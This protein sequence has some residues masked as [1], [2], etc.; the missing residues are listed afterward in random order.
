MA[1]NRHS[2]WFAA[3]LALTATLATS[4]PGTASGACT[5]HIYTTN[6]TNNWIW[7][8]IYDVGKATHMDWGWVGPNA[9][10]SWSGGG[11]PY[12]FFNQYFCGLTY[13][14][15][16]EV[17]AGG[18]Q[19]TP[20]VF[21]TTV[22]VNPS[23]GGNNTVCL[24]TNNNGKSYYWDYSD[25]CTLDRPGGGGG[26]F[27]PMLPIFSAAQS[28]KLTALKPTPH[29][30]PSVIKL[31]AADVRAPFGPNSAV[32]QIDVVVDGQKQPTTFGKLGKW[33]TSTPSEIQITDD[34]G[35]FRVLEAGTGSVTWTYAGKNYET[36][37]HAQ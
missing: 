4:Q 37:I 5:Q 11:S 15:R 30:Q 26:G 21:D 29:P 9:Y 18:P 24:Y 28:A 7:V 32:H 35:D 19:N 8:T 27:R 31:V 10:R 25:K 1:L 12:P 34:L 3:G 2:I 23:E 36:S 22:R 33:S 13:Y 16:A 14:V 17:K 20:N 6:Q